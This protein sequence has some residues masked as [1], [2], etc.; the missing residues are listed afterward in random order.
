MYPATPNTH[1]EQAKTNKQ[2]TN[3]NS[4]VNNK[5]LVIRELQLRIETSVILHSVEILFE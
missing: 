5:K 1:K 4:P 2:E 3:R